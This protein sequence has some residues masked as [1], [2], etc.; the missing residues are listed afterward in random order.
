VLNASRSNLR[1]A[2]RPQVTRQGCWL[3]TSLRLV[4]DTAAL[5]RYALIQAWYEAEEFCLTLVPAHAI[6]SIAL[7]MQP[8]SLF[9]S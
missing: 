3:A 5:R 4:F 9:S 2:M 8:V 7:D 6:F 1:K